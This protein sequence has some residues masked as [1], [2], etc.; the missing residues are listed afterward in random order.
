[1][2]A[3]ARGKQTKVSKH[4]GGKAV[5]KALKVKGGIASRYTTRNAALNRL[6]LKLADFR[7][8]CILKGIHPRYVSGGYQDRATEV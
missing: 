7:R 2:P 5:K 6:Q 4:G 8:L 3:A 1:M